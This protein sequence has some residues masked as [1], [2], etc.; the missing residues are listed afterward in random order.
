MTTDDIL[1]EFGADLWQ[2]PS[3]TRMAAE[4]VRL[5]ATAERVRS[6]ANNAVEWSERD[7][8]VMLLVADILAALE[9][10]NG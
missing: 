8:R 4:I 10:T 3:E 1:K 6:K 5:R 7:E 2:R 9:G